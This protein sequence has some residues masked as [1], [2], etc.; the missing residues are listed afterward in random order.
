VETKALLRVLARHRLIALD[1]CVLIYWLEGHDEF[2]PQAKAVLSRLQRGRN[3]AVLSTLALLEI[4]V[5]PYRKQSENLAD[6]YF[7]LLHE[8]PNCQWISMTYAIADLAAQL[9]A[10]HGIATPDAIHLATAIN[11]G[12]G[13]FVT[14]DRKLPEISQMDY[15]L[16]GRAEG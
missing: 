2:G 3:T 5:G 7:A 9:R 11:S 12:A 10:G 14:N 6:R 15:L 4:Q 13:L 16:I 1:S 8:L